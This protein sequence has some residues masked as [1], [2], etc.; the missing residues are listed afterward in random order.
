MLQVLIIE[1]E[2]NIGMLLTQILN[3]MG[4][5][6]IGI[7]GTEEG[8]V[9]AAV[10]CRPDLILAD[11]RLHPGSG[12]SALRRILDGGLIPHIWMGGDRPDPTRQEPGVTTL[13]K[14]FTDLDLELAIEKV[15]KEKSSSALNGER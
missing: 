1:D 15:C 5:K 7:E 12:H 3:G 10:R 9:A 14:P 11:A 13:R 6:V 4:H 8:A 2:V